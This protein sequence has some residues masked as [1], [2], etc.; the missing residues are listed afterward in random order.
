MS[1]QLHTVLALV[2]FS[3]SFR[4]RLARH[5][6]DGMERPQATMGYSSPEMVAALAAFRN[7]SE[8]WTKPLDF[9]AHDSWSLGC[10]LSTLLSGCRPFEWPAPPE[11]TPF[12]QPDPAEYLQHVQLRQQQW[13]SLLPV[14][15]HMGSACYEVGW[16][17][18]CCYASAL[19]HLQACL[20]CTRLYVCLQ[21]CSCWS[22]LLIWISRHM[23]SSSW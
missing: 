7:G 1:T 17:S 2:S 14:P 22:C 20:L 6:G 11:G 16:L 12:I 5:A 9:L 10:I 4:L 19:S 23:Q 8:T 15:Q 13:V 18:S 3:Y 21:V